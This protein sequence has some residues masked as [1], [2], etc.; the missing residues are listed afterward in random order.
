MGRLVK[1]AFAKVK[2]GVLVFDD[3]VLHGKIRNSVAHYRMSHAEAI[4]DHASLKNRRWSGRH[5]IECL[6]RREL[7]V[8]DIL[9]AQYYDGDY[10]EYKHFDGAVRLLAIEEAEGRN[11]VGWDLYMKMQKNG[12]WKPRF[13][14]LIESYGSTG[15]YDPESFLELDKHLAVMDGSHRLMLAYH[16]GQEFINAR[17]LNALRNR[18]FDRGFFWKNGFSEE[19]CRLIEERSR[20]ILDA[21]NYDFV[22]VVWPPAYSFAD[23]L[24]HDIS[25]YDPESVQVVGS[26]DLV[27]ER[28]DFIHFFKAL[29]HTDVLDESGMDT[30][31]R[32]I[33]SFMPGCRSGCGY[34]IR[35]FK[36][37]CKNPCIGINPKNLST[38]SRTVK[39]IKT[40]FRGRFAPRIENYKYDVIFH[41]SDNY[42][43]S[44]FCD[45]LFGI[46]RDISG[47]FRLLEGEQYVVMRAK[48]SRQHSE[49]PRK[50]YFRGDSD[51][52]VRIPDMGRMADLVYEF[53][54]RHFAYPWVRVEKKIGTE[55]A[56]V[57]VWL[58]DFMIFQ[59]EFVCRPYGLT[60]SF[61]ERCLRH[62]VDDG[63]YYILPDEDEI[64]I[65]ILEYIHKPKKTWYLDYIRSHIGQLD[66]EMLM[67]SL[68]K[69]LVSERRVRKFLSQFS[70]I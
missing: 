33:E 55:D 43:Q 21:C 51:I 38:Q 28:G 27:L 17:I 66:R 41:V 3:K 19:E 61:A 6:G 26:M 58:R 1:N 37:H 42:L 49:F 22:G 30:K 52:L 15:G 48:Q 12:F 53:S 57:I 29:Y 45:I 35:V 70:V 20:Q 23:E 60:D 16:Y 62:R 8:K 10:S 39:E 4:Y 54:R 24:L 56:K 65:R 9:L 18:S 31:I 44:M 68:D 25:A 13:V 69:G 36:L 40:A 47:A 50:F 34:P 46:D 63:S 59:F 7:S 67:T 5:R 14:N 32:L 11:Q 64:I 2:R